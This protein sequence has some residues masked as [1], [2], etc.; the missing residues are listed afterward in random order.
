MTIKGLIDKV[1]EEKPN[2]FTD[3]KVLGFINEIEEDVSDQLHEDF[4]PYT[5]VDDTEL[6]APAPY[7]RLYVSYVKSQIDYAN[8]EYASY[9]LNAEQHNQ[10]MS[11]FIN[12]VV[13]NGIAVNAYMPKRFRNIY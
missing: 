13:R 10:D 9:Q 4:E 11:D 8:E 2:T 1:Q 6:I 12:W 5:E 3:E 7:D